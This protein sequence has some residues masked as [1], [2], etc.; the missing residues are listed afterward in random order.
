VK[1]ILSLHMSIAHPEVASSDVLLA[2]SNP[3]E[4]YFD[5][6]RNRFISLKKL[7]DKWIIVV[8]EKNQEIIVTTAFYMKDQKKNKYILNKLS[9][10]SWIKI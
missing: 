8:Y 10:C 2:V 1:I 3:D 4:R 6:L 5:T 9:S 7:N